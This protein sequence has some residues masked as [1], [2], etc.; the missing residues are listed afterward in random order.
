MI[1]QEDGLD[2]SA[3]D[4]NTSYNIVRAYC[5]S[6]TTGYQT[7]VPNKV[8]D[9]RDA[10]RHAIDSNVEFMEIYQT[11]VLNDHATLSPFAPRFRPTPGA[12]HCRSRP[13]RAPTE[14]RS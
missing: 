2:G 6:A 5:G 3:N 13:R 12:S 11:D 8:I 14:A 10:V 7:R 1:V 9:L 4:S